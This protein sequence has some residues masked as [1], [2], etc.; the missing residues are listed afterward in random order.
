[1]SSVAVP[2]S[3]VDFHHHVMPV[4]LLPDSLVQMWNGKS[5]W[6]F[7]ARTPIWS[8]QRSIEF[9]DDLG[10][11]TSILSLPNDV[12]SMLPPRIRQGFA[13]EVNTFAK[14]MGADYP[15]RFGLFA[16]VPTPTDLDAALSEMTFALDE[17]HADVWS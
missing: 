17:L 15:G 8:P 7:P 4:G 13:R 9:M 11:D 6:Q 3:G 1:M 12:E 16:H 14:E 5:A 2:P 10:I